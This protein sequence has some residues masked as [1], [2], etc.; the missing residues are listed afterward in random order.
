MS[1]GLADLS[2]ALALRLRD[3]ARSLDRLDR[4]ESGTGEWLASQQ[5]EDLAAAA[6]AMTLRTLRLAADSDNYALLNRLAGAASMSTA[7]LELAVGL[8][9]LALVERINDLVQVGLASRNV[10]TD[11]VQATQAGAALA[12][13]VS[14]IS[15]TTAERLAE[16]LR[17]V[18][19]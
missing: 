19:R 9:R 12:G 13:L 3:L 8:G 7:E 16:A 10:D 14:A 6:Q 17:P 1:Q 18:T 4:L 11:Q 2:T 5:A 15:R